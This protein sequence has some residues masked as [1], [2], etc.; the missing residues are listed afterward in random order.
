MTLAVLSVVVPALAQRQR[1]V[2]WVPPAARV[3]VESARVDF[4][5]SAAGDAGKELPSAIVVRVFSPRPW[6]LRLMPRAALTEHEHGQ[7]VPW[8]RV[9]WRTRTN[10]YQLVL[11]AGFVIA[12][13]GPTNSSGELVSV[14][15]RIV[16]AGGDALGNFG[17]AIKVILDTW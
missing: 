9:E 12:R 16:F 17:G 2:V 11:P 15:L 7:T 6:S 3:E 1:A 14:D 5:S 8:E 13:G 4:G 10:P